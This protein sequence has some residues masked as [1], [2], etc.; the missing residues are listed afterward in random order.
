[1]SFARRTLGKTRVEQSDHVATRSRRLAFL[2]VAF[3]VA[4]VSMSSANTLS[5]RPQANQKY[6]Y[7]VEI[8]A[9]LPGET[10]TL[11]GVIS[12]DVE[13]VGEL[14]KLKYEGGLHKSVKPKQD[15]NMR[16]RGFSGPP[17]PR[18]PSMFDRGMT[19]RGL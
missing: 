9:D 2:A 5:Y 7:E 14:L 10:E 18:M 13:S 1:M 8:T 3:L 6:A 4:G 11:K 17:V 16:R 19:Y 15:G 12:Y